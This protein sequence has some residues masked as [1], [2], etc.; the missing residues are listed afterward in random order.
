MESCLKFLARKSYNTFGVVLLTSFVLIGV[1]VIGI[2]IDFETKATLHCNPTNPDK[3]IA[4]DLSTRKFINRQCFLKYQNKF[5]FYMPL[6]CLFLINF[7][8]VTLVSIIYAYWVKH[9]VEIFVDQPNTTIN[10]SD[11][12]NQPLLG[13]SEAALDPIAHQ[14]SGCCTVFSLYVTHLIS[15]RVITLAV[16]GALLL[17]LNF[18]VHFQCQWQTD[19]GCTSDSKFTQSQIS[20]Y[21]T[22]DCIYPTGGKNEN[23]IR[24]VRITNLVFGTAALTELAY[25]LWSAWKDRSFCTDMEFCCV[26]LLRKR[27]RIRK[28]MKTIR[29]NISDYLFYLHDDFGEKHLSRRKLEEMYVNVII[30]EGRESIWNSR[31]TFKNRHEMYEVHF[32]A[33]TNALTLTRTEDLFKRTSTPNNDPRTILVVGRPG[34]GKTLLTKTLF[35]QWQQQVSIFWHDKIV[36]LIRFRAFNN[37]QTSLREMLRHSDGF[38]MATADFN[39]F[40]EYICLMPSNV[41]LVFDGLDELRVDE[42]F[43]PEQVTVNGHN[44]VT[45]VLGI[46][47]QLVKGQLLPGATVLT[48]SRPT[49]E[50][51]YKTLKFDREIEILGF[52]EEQIKHYVE[53][54]CCSDTQESSEIWN[55]IKQSPELLG[56]CYIPVNSYIVCLTLKE[57]IGIDENKRDEGQDNV[58]KTITE[59]YKRAIKILLF[60]HNL[61]Y[62]DRQTPKDYVIAKLPDELQSDLNELKVIARDGIRKDQLVFEFQNGDRFV[63]ELSDCGVFNKLEDKRQNMFCFLHLTIQEF[64]AALHVVDEIRNVE[65]FLVDHIDDPKWHL[66]IQFVCG[67]I[68]DKIKELQEDSN[69]SEM[70]DYV[71]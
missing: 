23:L 43:L 10:S 22:V 19:T 25:L 52:Q 47:K 28:L 68:G 71:Y 12:E 51:I 1:V 56:L 18:P 63:E 53:K 2:A 37:K 14:R 44:D 9:R 3:T 60:K 67:L 59:L 32:T 62:K 57:S 45:H 7:G 39:C 27:K 24:A 8:L 50:R 4:S 34:I 42:M 70:Y 6:Y 17:K 30:L 20:N 29:E 26:Y 40:Y 64:L 33:P 41:I 48:T 69:G 35:Y 15:G 13:I 46:F 11:E 16:I 66:V 54:F 58:P 65:S 38:N 49:A 31:R 5:Y 55:L 36:I 61:K 21:S